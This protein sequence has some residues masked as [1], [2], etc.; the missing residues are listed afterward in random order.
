[1]QMQIPIWRSELGVDSFEI[2]KMQEIIVEPYPKTN[3]ESKNFPILKN[4]NCIIFFIIYA[5]F[6]I[7]K[8]FRINTTL[9]SQN[10]TENHFVADIISLCT[11]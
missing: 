5:S 4:C 9:C 10:C 3:A 11:T 2:W 7:K 6:L 8:L 1:M